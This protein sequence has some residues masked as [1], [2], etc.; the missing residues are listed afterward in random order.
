LVADQRIRGFVDPLPNSRGVVRSAEPRASTKMP[1]SEMS[2]TVPTFWRLQLS[3]RIAFSVAMAL[4]RLGMYP[5]V[6]AR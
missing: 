3:G 5:L 2:R 6:T 4:S 1:N